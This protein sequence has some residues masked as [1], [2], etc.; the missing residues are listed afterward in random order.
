VDNDDIKN[1]L[2]SNSLS[3]A[4]RNK[5]VKRLNSE[6]TDMNFDSDEETQRTK[7]TT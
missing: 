6:Q 7:V 2:M 4:L 3:K 5:S 1:S